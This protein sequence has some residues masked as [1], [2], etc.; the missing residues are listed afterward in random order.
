MIS[1]TL[2]ATPT[3]QLPNSAGIHELMNEGI[4]APLHSEAR[5]LAASII[6]LVAK[7]VLDVTVALA[8]CP[9]I[10]TFNETNDSAIK[11]EI[12]QILTQA[13]ERTQ[14]ILPPQNIEEI[15]EN[16]TRKDIHM[17][18]DHAL[19]SGYVSNELHAIIISRSSELEGHVNAA[20]IEKF[21]IRLLVLQSVV[22]GAVQE[23]PEMLLRY[24]SSILQLTPEQIGGYQFDQLLML[25]V[26]S[27]IRPDQKISTSRSDDRDPRIIQE[28]TDKKLR[29]LL[30]QLQ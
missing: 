30:F 14:A 13:Q 7:N 16:I 23:T 6:S 17:L 20:W 18:A 11:A 3:Q 27:R 1:P 15:P 5:F 10:R 22:G 19:R 25:Y 4:G 29:S 26:K 21:T 24:Q 2:S 9:R 8:L 12:M 28:S